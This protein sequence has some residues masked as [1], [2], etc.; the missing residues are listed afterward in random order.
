MITKKYRPRFRAYVTFTWDKEIQKDGDSAEELDRWIDKIL[1]RY[2]PSQI[3]STR[4]LP[5]RAELC[6]PPSLD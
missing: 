1:A 6:L 4:I 3:A 5:L 2:K